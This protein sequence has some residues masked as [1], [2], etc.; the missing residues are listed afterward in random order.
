VNGWAS[1]VGAVLAT[2]LAMTLGFRGLALTAASL[3]A[4]ASILLARARV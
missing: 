2:L 1:V 4:A 3:Y